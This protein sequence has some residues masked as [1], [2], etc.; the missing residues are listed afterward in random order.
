M[1]VYLKDGIRNPE[2]GNRN[3]ES[4]IKEKTKMKI[5]RHENFNEGLSHLG[6]SFYSFWKI[7][8]SVRSPVKFSKV[9]LRFQ[10]LRQ[11]SH[12]FGIK[13]P[14]LQTYP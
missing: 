1:F 14:D 3:P 6:N 5:R 12:S 10:L 2:S 13:V 11:L 7:V 9:S 8:I 4:G